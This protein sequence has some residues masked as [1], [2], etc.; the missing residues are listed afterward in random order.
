[1]RLEGN[2]FKRAMKHILTER[3][4]QSISVYESAIDAQVYYDTDTNEFVISTTESD[5]RF[6]TK[7]DFVDAIRYNINAYC[8][9]MAERN[10]VYTGLKSYLADVYGIIAQ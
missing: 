8:E 3:E 4:C 5:E 1:M 10:P 2:E 9:L 6:I 7:E